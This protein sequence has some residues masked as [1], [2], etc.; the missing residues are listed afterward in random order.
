MSPSLDGTLPESMIPEENYTPLTLYI[1][2][3]N[4]KY[5]LDIN[6]SVDQV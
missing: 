3:H 4:F 5:F 1:D 2:F 6:S